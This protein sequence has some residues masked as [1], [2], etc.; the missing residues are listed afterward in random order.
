MIGRDGRLKK[1]KKPK[2]AER[3]KLKRLKFKEYAKQEAE[4]FDE[5]FDPNNAKNLDG[6]LYGF[7]SNK[8]EEVRVA[9]YKPFKEAPFDLG[10]ERNRSNRVF[11]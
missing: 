3:E 10:R 1:D 7:K 4:I 6:E 9:S 8:R 2:R 11:K 5:K